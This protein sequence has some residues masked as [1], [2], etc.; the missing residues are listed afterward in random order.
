MTLDAGSGSGSATSLA[1]APHDREAERL[2]ALDRYKILDTPRELAF[3]DLTELASE[4]CRTPIAVVNLIAEGRQW[5]KAEVGLGVRETPLETSFCAHAILVEDYLEVPDATLD[6]RFNCNPLVTADGGLRFYAGA[7]LKNENGL[8]IGTLCVLD[9]SPRRLTGRQAGALKS[10]ARQVMSQLELRLALQARTESEARLRELNADLERQVVERTLARGRVWQVSPDLLGLADE[11]GYLR[12][13]NPA[14]RRTLGWTEHDLAQVPF[15]DLIHPD[16]VAATREAFEMAKRGEPVLAFENRFR[17]KEG[18][19]RWLSWVAVAEGRE[20]FSSGRDVTAEKERQATLEAAEDAL[21]QSQK[22][23]AVG[24]LTGGVAHDF[25]NLL[26]VIRSSTDLLRR[27]DLPEERRRRYV[28]AISDTVDR[29]A[30]LTSQLLAFARRQALKPEVF[31]VAEQ[32]RAV[33]DMMGTLSGARIE[34]ITEVVDEPCFVEADASQFETAL[35]NMAINA[36]DAMEGQGLLRMRVER[37][38]AIP[39]I[40]GHSAGPGA[41]VAIS[42]SDTGSGIPAEKLPLIFEP[43]F[44]TKPIGKGTGLG[45]SQVYGFAKQSGG[46]VGVEST[47]GEGT[48]FTLYLPAVEGSPG[49]DSLAMGLPVARS[50]PERSDGRRV[51]VVEDNVEVSTFVRQVLEDL[52]FEVTWA[53]NADEAL[54]QLQRADGFDVVF[55][56]VVMPGMSGI[57]LGQELRRTRP[58][59]PF[60]LTS[61]YSHVLAEE[62]LHGF[63]LLKKPYAADD[64]ARLLRKLTG[65]RRSGEPA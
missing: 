61:G 59:L 15:F 55:S 60:V 51:L 7:L 62:G 38:D 16:D 37:V 23:E 58:G 32:L 5:F 39:A 9:T 28:E 64:L 1:A 30:R 47:V 56:D 45:L 3:D 20:V 31:D 11:R 53:A 43:F 24:Q 54:Q 22:M 36:R 42:F 19:Y 25:N 50:A 17:R 8:P 52:G 40:R 48:T 34:I 35:V 27:P 41:F 10:L 18:G 46:D 4:I 2:A 29:A 26:T 63:E 14:W 13:T 21:R 65:N 49:R 12:T 33:A 6:P 44:T 57:E